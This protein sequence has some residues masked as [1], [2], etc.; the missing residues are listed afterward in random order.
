[1][2]AGCRQQ[3]KYYDEPSAHRSVQHPYLVRNSTPEPTH[4][5][6][7]INSQQNVAISRER[8]CCR[9][10]SSNSNFVSPPRYI[11]AGRH[12]S[13]LDRSLLAS[14]QR[15]DGIQRFNTGLADHG[16]LCRSRMGACETSVGA[17]SS[18]H[19]IFKD[20]FKDTRSCC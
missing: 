11:Q 5:D 9:G 16:M 6:L 7:H 1:M 3:Y 8:H 20:A 18:A 4:L 17:R 13:C 15:T 12:I 14:H 19:R 10:R 2:E